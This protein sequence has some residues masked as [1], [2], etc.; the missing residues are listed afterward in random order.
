[1][2]SSADAVFSSRPLA[3]RGGA[4]VPHPCSL[5][6]SRTHPAV[7]Q[8]LSCRA[9]SFRCSAGGRH[10]CAGGVVAGVGSLDAL[11]GPL[12]PIV[13]SRGLAEPTI[14]PM[15]WWG[16]AGVRREGA[17]R[18]FRFAQCARPT[19][20]LFLAPGGSAGGRK[21][22]A[23]QV[24]GPR[25][26]AHSVPNDVCSGGR[27][28]AI[29]RLRPPLPLGRV[30]VGKCSRTRLIRPSPFLRQVPS[31][32]DL[33][34]CC[35]R[36]AGECFVS[37]PSLGECQNAHRAPRARPAS[38]PNGLS[39][40]GGEPCLHIVSGSS[41]RDLH[42]VCARSPLLLALWGVAS[43]VAVGMCSQAC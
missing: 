2:R 32:S 3:R 16:I 18:A 4:S 34:P 36:M 31:R 22:V 5:I 10:T 8:F 41:A 15:S 23:C 9:P 21:R 40:L 7:S 25:A 33:V 12:A 30:G 27:S 39:K 1:M 38:A 19:G 20:G 37:Q 29:V 13:C 14:V 17:A 26:Q 43:S 35:P 11:G 6:V 28:P 24:A 42:V